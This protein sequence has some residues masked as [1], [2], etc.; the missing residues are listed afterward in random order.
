MPLTQVARQWHAARVR[1]RALMVYSHGMYLHAVDPPP[2]RCPQGSLFASMCTSK[3]QGTDAVRRVAR[4]AVW[5]SFAHRD[6][7]GDR[8]SESIWV[9]DIHEMPSFGHD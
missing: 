8:S 7:L 5:T 6:R 9:I 1:S 2:V 4:S 3:A